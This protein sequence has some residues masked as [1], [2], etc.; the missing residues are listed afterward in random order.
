MFV[1]GKTFQPSVKKHSFFLGPFE[2][3][4]ENEESIIPFLDL[5]TNILYFYNLECLS[6]AN[7]SSLVQSNT[8]AYWAHSKVM[9]KMK[10]F[11]YCPGLA[12]KYF[13]YDQSV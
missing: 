1:P 8:L 12:S 3:Y 6:L 7:L 10:C 2:S 4:E 5:L 13:Y 11:N 9:K